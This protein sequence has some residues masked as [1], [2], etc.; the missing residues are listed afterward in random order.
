MSRNE[1]SYPHYMRPITI[2]SFVWLTHIVRELC[3]VAKAQSTNK[4]QKEEFKDITNGISSV[5]PGFP[6]V[7]GKIRTTHSRQKQTAVTTTAVT[8]RGDIAILSR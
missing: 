2:N 1:I 8:I 7:S 4:T 5:I 3:T 6:D